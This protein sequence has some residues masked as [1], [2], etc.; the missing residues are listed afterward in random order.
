MYIH[1]YFS[2]LLLSVRTLFDNHIFSN[3]YIRSYQFNVGSRIFQLDKDY[4]TGF[5]LPAAIISLG[6]DNL[7][8]GQKTI[9]ALHL[10]SQNFDQIPVLHDKIND[11]VLYIQE[12]MSMITINCIINSDSQLQ[13][14]E[15]ESQIRR[16]LPLNKYI[17]IFDFVSFLEIDKVYINKLQFNTN[18]HE[19]INL[20]TKINKRTG[21]VNHCFSIKYEPLI[22]L[23]AANVGITDSSQRSF[24]TTVDLTYLIQLPIH[25]FSRKF[26]GTIERININF[27]QVFEPISDVF[28]ARLITADD[29]NKGYIRRTVIISSEDD[30]VVDYSTIFVNSA[31]LPLNKITSQSEDNNL[32]LTRLV[33]NKILINIKNKNI[34]ITISEDIDE[35]ITIEVDNGNLIISKDENDIISVR[36][37]KYIVTLT[38]QFN[39]NDFLITSDYTYN[40]IKNESFVNDY[41]NTIDIENNKV[42][43]EF[44]Q[45]DWKTNY[46]PTIT[47]PLFV[48]FYLS[49]E[50]PRSVYVKEEE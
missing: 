6:T 44:T 28:S 23:E 45:S 22:R 7:A 8:F 17:Q 32:I 38:I 20:F 12:E 10:P 27:H 39:K 1:N 3:D 30:G 18:D 11:T 36:Q 41:P 26:P 15:I 35:E 48:Q 31:A 43:F 16:F 21:D 46:Q 19:I 13:G 49:D 42:T 47:S 29:N 33:N 24:Q 14:K 50:F 5:E 34:S 25:L 37:N 4:R 40:L 9:T 2:D